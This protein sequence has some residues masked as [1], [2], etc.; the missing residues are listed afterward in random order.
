MENT[1]PITYARIA[2]VLTE[3]GMISEAKARSVRDETSAY[4]TESIKRGHE[5]ASALQSFGVAVS[6]HAN[7]VDFA[8]E[9]Y[10]WL[11]DEAAGLTDGTVTVSDYRFEKDDPEDEDSG[12]GTMHFSRNGEPL[13]FDVMQESND[14]LDTQAAR[15]AI[16]ALLPADDPRDFS[17]VERQ[18]FGDDIMVLATAEQR[19]G[20][21]LHLG[22]TFEP[23][24]GPLGS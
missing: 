15:R 14:Y 19:E 18:D 9:H 10:D 13:S 8:D 3:L 17:C 11:L 4:A 20:L 24:L 23:P 12:L 22:I 16:Q 2:E 5:V 21:R 1:L 6:I 7:D